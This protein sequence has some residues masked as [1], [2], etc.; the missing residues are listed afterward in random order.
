MG[1]VVTGIVLCLVTLGGGAYM[2]RGWLK[3]EVEPPKQVVQE[4]R[5]IRPPPPEEQPPPPPPPP[6]EEEKVDL[7]E[8]QPD[9]TP[10]DEPPPGNLLGL[11]AEGSGGGDGFGL[12]GRPGGRDL[13]ATGGSAFSWYAGLIKNE[14][15][16]ALDDEKNVRSG[17]YSVVVRVWVAHDGT[18]E[19]ASLEGSSGDRERDRAI[20]FALSQLQR[21][22]QAPPANMPQPISLRIV[23]RV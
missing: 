18:V 8:P 4:V 5:I 22:S 1:P 14:I 2:V 7:N 10:S 15:L 3:T 17:A 13:L 20:E 9:P 6:P 11:D 19:K 16:D 23:S 12:V 21:L